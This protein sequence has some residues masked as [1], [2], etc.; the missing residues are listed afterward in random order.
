MARNALIQVRRDTAA[1]WTSTN[2]TLAAGEMGFET[3]TGKFKI[4]TGSTAWTS[5]LY[6]TDASDITGA[7]LASNVVSS[8]L[9]SV[10]T[11]GSLGVT[12]ATTSGSFVQGTDYLS[13]YQ[14]FRNKII[15]GDFGINQRGFTSTTTS[16]TYGFDRW[17]TFHYNNTTYSA[18]TFTAG[19]AISGQEPIN[20]ARIVTVSQPSDLSYAYLNQKIEDVRTCAGQTVTVSFWA[21]SGSGTPQV[22]V[23]L[24]QNFGTGGSSSVG[25]LS[26]LFTLSTG[27]QRFTANITLP[28]ISGK[29]IGS[30][31][32]LELQLWVSTSSNV[33]IVP[34]QNNTFD[35]WGVQ[36]EQ[37]S[38]ATP[39]E[40]RPIQTELAL[41]QRYYQKSYTQ[42]VTPGTVSQNGALTVL[43]SAGY[44]ATFGFQF[45]TTMRAAPSITLY[46]QSSGTV[47]RVDSIG[48]GDSTYT[49]GEVGD[50]GVRYLLL[51]SGTSGCVFHYV[52]SSEL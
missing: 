41:C 7:T 31:S 40:Q 11:L 52:A 13:P 16:T 17:Q 42:S 10:G 29:T 14:G 9:T 21:K 18:Q 46:S 27:W 19:N 4:G 45:R 50:S 6:A 8:S 30:S 33:N 12:G 43:Y 22:R 26:S 34:L 37:G 44:G 48:V 35:F 51:G 49:L 28:S 1:N 20:F 3:D 24:S 38:V 39:F 2:P 25:T 23:G 5:L 32:Y 47:S 15:N 36:V